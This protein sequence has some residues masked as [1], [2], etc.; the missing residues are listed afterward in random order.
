MIVVSLRDLNI[1]IVLRLFTLD[2]GYSMISV[3]HNLLTII[4]NVINTYYILHN[5]VHNIVYIYI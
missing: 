4:L 3:L 5:I 1:T 2:V